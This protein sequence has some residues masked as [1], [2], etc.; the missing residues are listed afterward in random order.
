MLQE[1]L[2]VILHAAR[3]DY[4]VLFS[5]KMKADANIATKH[6]ARGLNGVT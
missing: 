1:S 5:I 3:N 4:L 6:S 2:I